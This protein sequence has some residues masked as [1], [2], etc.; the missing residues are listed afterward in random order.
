LDIEIIVFASAQRQIGRAL[1]ALGVYDGLDEIAIV[2][3]GTE[4]TSVKSTIQVLVEKI[5]KEVIPPFSA[6]VERIERIKTH[7]NISDK[8]IDA[9]SDSNRIES[10]LAALSRCLVSRVSLVAFDS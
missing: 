5:G 3:V 1:D 10:K 7:F 4:T 6:T 9:I 2:V 8:E